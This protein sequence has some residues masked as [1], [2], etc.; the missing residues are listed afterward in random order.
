MRPVGNP[1]Q[2]A[3]TLLEVLLVLAVLLLLVSITGGI[4]RQVG[5]VRRTLDER[6]R[7]VAT[8]R[9]ALW[10]VQD[11]LAAHTPGSLRIER[12]TGHDPTVSFE[13]E[14]PTPQRIDYGVE[15][16]RLVRR[17]NDRFRT[18]TRRHRAVVAEQV[19]RFEVAALGPDGWLETWSSP[20][21]PRALALT[22]ECAGAP[23]LSMTLTPQVGG[24]G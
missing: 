22:I 5:D 11:E 8:A 4:V 15:R 10:V 24:A 23:R 12:R 20:R 3:F 2:R 21:A 6:T 18:S 9:S 17:V 7:R 13:V 16:G 14:A 1:R 19:R